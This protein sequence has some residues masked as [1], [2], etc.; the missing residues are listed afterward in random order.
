MTGL[1]DDTP[2]P[3]RATVRRKL[4]K[5]PV[6]TDP[7]A[8]VPPP[9]QADEAAKPPLPSPEPADNGPTIYSV[10]RINRLIQ[11][12]LAAGLP[13]AV[14]VEGEISNFS[15]YGKGHAFFKLKDAASE[16]SCMMWRDTLE[17]L[18]FKPQN[19]L[20]VLAQGTVKV[21]EPQGRINFYINRLTPL[22]AGALELAFR[23]LCEK[24]RAEGLF[25]SDR[26]RPLPQ[27]PRRIIVVT[28]P[29]GDVIHDVLITAW[30]RF[31]GLHVMIYPVQV[32]GT[33][34]AGQIA[35]ALKNIN[36]CAQELRPD[37]VLLVRGG[38]SM[39]D[40][41]AFNEEIVA[42]AIAASAIPIATGIGHEPDITIADLVADLRGPTPTGV[43]ELTIPDVRVLRDTYN[44]LAGTLRRQL[45]L[46][47]LGADREYQASA[48]RLS[49]AMDAQFR[50]CRRRLA[51][52]TPQ[53][54][55]I[56]P[57]YTIAE[58]W[59]RI[60]SARRQ[61]IATAQRELR[62]G[63]QH[64]AVTEAG[65]RRESPTIM[66]ARY[67]ERLTTLPRILTDA[68][69]V[70]YQDKAKSMQAVSHKLELVGPQAVLNR[71]FSIT[72]D[73]SGQVLRSVR[74]VTPGMAITTRLSDGLLK[75]D[76]A[77]ISSR[78]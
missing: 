42:R 54:A 39:E 69:R 71:G 68:V 70:V 64:L 52:V 65:L 61:L 76:N 43:T 36:A 60:E 20:A 57:R 2:A 33:Q 55:A 51:A 15:I 16:I 24:L 53:I 41:W 63:R 27:L 10:S 44:G 23:Q 7:P 78:S 56:E 25:D 32:Q 12:A 13:G 73:S 19:G 22:G 14:L 17:A 47:L 62:R 75:S 31:A 28:S 30:R 5:S 26:K 6:A 8:S 38:G 46:A 9:V 11:Q 58:G 77:K 40:L 29:T 59:R 49:D 48:R 1:F 35:A 21:Y 34:A 45:D 74:Q 66:L 67:S 50:Q 37:L 72:T 18:R 3:K 4:R